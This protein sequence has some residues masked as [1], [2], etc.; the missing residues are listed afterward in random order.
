MDD[1][2]KIKRRLMRRLPPQFRPP[3][4][5]DSLAEAANLCSG[6]LKVTVMQCIMEVD[7]SVRFSLFCKLKPQLSYAPYMRK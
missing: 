6:D 7:A 5:T 1:D 3:K 4:P 2:K